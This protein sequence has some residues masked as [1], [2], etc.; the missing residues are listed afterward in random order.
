MKNNQDVYH[1]LIKPPK[2]S[3]DCVYW[4]SDYYLHK[5]KEIYNKKHFRLYEDV[6]NYLFTKNAD[7]KLDEWP[8]IYKLFKKY[9]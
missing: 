9:V 4:V 8:D 3:E 1:M 2:D 6:T 5:D 7:K